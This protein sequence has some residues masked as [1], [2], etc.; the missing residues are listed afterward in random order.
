MNKWSDNWHRFT[1]EI[2]EPLIPLVNAR[3]NSVPYP[4]VS[5]YMFWTTIYDMTLRKEHRFT[6]WLMRQSDKKQHEYF[7]YLIDHFDD[8]KTPGSWME[9]RI[10]EEAVAL[11][12]R[13]EVDDLVM[14]RAEKL[15]KKNEPQKGQQELGLD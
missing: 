4:S 6:P 10:R 2:P 3:K 1:V 15:R 5:K 7:Q 14:K 8:D 13:G 12:E 11:I 9:T